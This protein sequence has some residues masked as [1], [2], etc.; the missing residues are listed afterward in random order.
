MRYQ[1][2]QGSTPADADRPRRADQ[3]HRRVPHL[4]AHA[5]GS[6]TS[7]RRCEISPMRRPGDHRSLRLRRHVLSGN[8]QRRGG[9]A[10]D[11]R[12]GADDRGHQPDAAADPDRARHRRRA[13]REGRPLAGAMVNVMQRMGAAVI[14]NSAAPARPTA[15][16]RSR[17]DARR[18][19]APRQS[20]G[21]TGAATRSR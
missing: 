18:V 16:S 8:R 14:G 7:R 10:A 3:R 1:F 11:D 5:R 12:A 2:V 15:S 21:P 4:R 13:G 6:T 9:A 20:A 19:H 17:P